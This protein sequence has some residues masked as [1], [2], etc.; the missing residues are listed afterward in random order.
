MCESIFTKYK[1]ELAL[2]SRKIVLHIL[3][4]VR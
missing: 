3:V 4:C 2:A 1:I